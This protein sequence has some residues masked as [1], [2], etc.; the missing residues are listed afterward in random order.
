MTISRAKLHEYFPPDYESSR[1]Q[2]IERC[3]RHGGIHL[4]APIE[5]TTPSGEPLSLDIARF[6]PQD[7][8]RVLALSS[9]THGVEGFLGAAIQSATVELKLQELLS[10]EGTALLLIHAVNPFGFAHLRRVNEDNVD[11]NRNFLLD[12]ERYEGAAQGYRALDPFLNPP[13]P[14]SPLELFKLKALLKIARY[15]LPALK[16]S[17][18]QGQYEHPKG[19]FFGGHEASA[20]KRVI[21]EGLR[22]WLEGAERVIHIDLH[23]GLGPWGSYVLASSAGLPKPQ[24]EWL[25]A[26]F[27]PARVQRLE[28][29]GL[30]YQIRGEFTE[31]CREL[32]GAVEYYPVLAEFGTYPI[33]RVLSALRAENRATHHCAPDDPRLSAAR[34][35]LREAFAPQSEAWRA[36]TLRQ[37]LE[38]VSQ[39]TRALAQP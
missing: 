30:L 14:P 7:A 27:D 39:A 9:G 4:S 5:A 13:S 33:L 34:L 17:V 16:A 19:L 20:S 37:G 29:E 6:G 38:I 1:A 26:H 2:F 22:G 11:L 23:T 15:G 12:Q 25:M 21:D 24:L 31:R 3:Q 35:A 8:P 18:A 32:C 36:E 28:E 10:Y